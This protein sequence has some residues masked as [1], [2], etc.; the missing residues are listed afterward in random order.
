MLQ[1][2]RCAVVLATAAASIGCENGKME[3]DDNK[4][5]TR[6]PTP[7]ASTTGD[8]Q[9]ASKVEIV[10]KPAIRELLRISRIE[11]LAQAVAFAPDGRSFAL[12]FRFSRPRIYDTATGAFKQAVPGKIDRIEALAFS[13]EGRLLAFSC[14]NHKAPNNIEGEIRVWNLQTLATD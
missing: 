12:G 10:E 8:S 2:L 13:P 5:R 4:T 3:S 14:W 1:I 9:E 7:M 11:G 6:P